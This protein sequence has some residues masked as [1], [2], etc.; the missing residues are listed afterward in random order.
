[1]PEVVDKVTARFPRDRLLIAV[2]CFENVNQ[3]SVDEVAT[4]FDWSLFSTYDLNPP[5]RNPAL[6]LGTVGWVPTLSY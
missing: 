6:L 5:G 1:V 3:P 4:R 2:Q